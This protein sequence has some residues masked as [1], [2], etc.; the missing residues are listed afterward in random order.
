MF[1]AQINVH[2]L[3]F[4]FLSLNYNAEGRHKTNMKQKQSFAT[5]SSCNFVIIRFIRMGK[6]QVLL[7]MI[8]IKALIIIVNILNSDKLHL[9]VDRQYFIFDVLGNKFS[10]YWNISHINWYSL[11]D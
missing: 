3:N 7:N 5:C 6:V 2:H 8:Y 1:S 11:G 10:T 9:D 4:S